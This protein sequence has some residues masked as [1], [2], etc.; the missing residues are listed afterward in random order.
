MD[1]FAFIHPVPAAW[2]RNSD[3]APF[4]PAY[5]RG[6]IDQQYAANTVRGYLYG[7]AHFARWARRSRLAVGDVT[8][9]NV[10]R[11][12]DRHLAG[13]TCPQPVGAAFPPPTTRSAKTPAEFAGP[14]RR[15]RPA[16]YTRPGARGTAPFRRPHAPC[17]RIGAEHAHQSFAAA[18]TFPSATWQIQCWRIVTACTA[19][20]APV[21]QAAAGAS[22]PRQCRGPGQRAARIFTLQSS[23]WGVGGRPVAGHCVTRELATGFATTDTVRVR[24]CQAARRVPARIAIVAPCLRHGP[25]RCRSGSANQ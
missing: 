23:R 25:L 5:W 16:S 7:V 17:Q 15:C 6:L 14:C 4:I 3:L 21:H 11:F 8:A 19:T 22:E 1:A 13:C 24:G 18:H 10:E 2:L 20:P 12:L 9:E